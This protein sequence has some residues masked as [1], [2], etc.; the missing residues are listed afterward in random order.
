MTYM[1]VS[2]LIP[3]RSPNARGFVR[4][5]C[6]RN[7]GIRRFFR[8]FCASAIG[9]VTNVWKRMHVG[10]EEIDFLGKR[11]QTQHKR[12]ETYRRLE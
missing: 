9:C 3:Q 2:G 4:N 8:A 10:D 5:V 11:I 7:G 6:K 1:A 12:I